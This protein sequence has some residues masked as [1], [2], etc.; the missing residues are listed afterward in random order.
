MRLYIKV[1]SQTMR[2]DLRGPHF[3]QVATRPEQSS[4]L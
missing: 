3:A 2:I 1:N 4:D